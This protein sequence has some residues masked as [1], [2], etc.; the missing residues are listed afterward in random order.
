MPPGP[1]GERTEGKRGTGTVMTW[2]EE[3]HLMAFA[4]QG[5]YHYFTGGDR[6]LPSPNQFLP[7]KTNSKMKNRKLFPSVWFLV[8]N[9]I[10]PFFQNGMNTNTWLLSLL[11]WATSQWSPSSPSPL[12][13][14]HPCQDTCDGR[15][16]CAAKLSS[17]GTQT[18]ATCWPKP[19]QLARSEVLGWEGCSL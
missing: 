8:G 7:L 17:P 14:Q 5:E 12:N 19:G 9:A 6:P 18:P 10:K 1:P 4:F 2:L 15:G 3:S 13:S 11:S 16:H